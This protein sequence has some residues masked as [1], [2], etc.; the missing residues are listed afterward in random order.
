MPFSTHGRK[1]RVRTPLRLQME[2]V[3]CGAASLAMVLEFF[4]RYIPLAELRR[5]CGVSRDGSKASN[6]LR[7]A[8][9]YGMKAKGFKKD[10][11]ALVDVRLPAILFW[12]FN[13]FVVFEGFGRNCAYLND[14]ARGRRRLT[15][16]EFDR[17]FTGVVLVMEPD[18]AFEKGGRRPSLIGAILSR[19]RGSKRAVAFCF[20][21]GLM[22]VLP[23]L[24]LP[25]FTQMFL[26]QVLVE[27]RTDWLPAIVTAMLALAVLQGVL[28]LVR[29]RYLR[30]LRVSLAV[31]LSSRFLWHLLRLPLSF[32]GQRFAGEIAGRSRLN[33]RVAYVLSGRLAETAIDLVTMSFFPIVMWGYSP[34]LMGL[35]LG[36]AAL[37]FVILESMRRRRAEV[38]ARMMLAQG[39]VAGESIAAL[40]SMETLKAS[41]LEAS[42]FSRWAGHHARATNLRQDME[43]SNQWLQVLP[44]MLS[45]LG[46]AAT[47]GLGGRM[48]MNGQLTL[49]QLVAF[50]ALMTGFLAPV[51]RMVDLGAMIQE[52]ETDLA[53]LDDVLDHPTE[54]ALAPVVD[55]AVEGELRLRGALELEKVEFGYS[56][57]E[58]PLIS[59]FSLKLEPGQ[60]VALV[61]GSGSGKST[62]AN[63]VSGLFHPWS[64]NILFDQ[65]TRGEIPRHV[66][67]NSFAMV[68]QEIF[69]FAGSVRDNLTLWDGTV[70]DEALLRALEDAAILDVVHAMPGGLDAHL[71]E[72]GT[73][74]SGGQRQR[75]EIARSL[76]HDPSI[77]VLDE[78]TS[79][80]DADTERIIDERLRLR[81]CTC[82]IVA[83]RL[84]TIRDCD[85]II[86]L[87]RG[88]VVQRGTHEELWS[89]SGAY[90]RLLEAD[91]NANEPAVV[92]E[93]AT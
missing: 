24:V 10:C 44:P 41:G 23:S 42:F 29:S 56:Q 85:E 63:M 36:V 13:H 12:N 19:L 53:R 84:S 17:G 9:H 25:A 66:F 78:A 47:L 86:V 93:G 34:P 54:E 82:L 37:D 2:A 28:F 89:D 57:L 64:G 91:E 46:F 67:L 70:P 61:G 40:Q 11:A 32:Y 8:R 15:L 74:L 43:V 30:R 68:S 39:K 58:P 83:H 75:L 38:N 73:N 62:V 6:I 22:L 51:A 88:K 14:P 1:R 4:G 35:A 50:Q 59:G 71:L 3:E 65:R 27:D 33:D 48:V 87:D 5:I 81:G 92:G 26:D 72:G 69:L 76:I 7:A 18:Q 52:L 79:A 21:A 55:Q 60:R 90:R 80:L 20:L 31:R 77:L 16:E 49:G 45:A